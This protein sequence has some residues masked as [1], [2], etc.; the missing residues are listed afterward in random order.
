MTQHN[1]SKDDVHSLLWASVGGGNVTKTKEFLDKYFN[2]ADLSDSEINE[3]GY[4]F[5]RA[6]NKKSPELLKLLIDTYVA[7]KLQGDVYSIEYLGYK[8]K[9]ATMLEYQID[10]SAYEFKEL[11]PEIQ[12]ILTP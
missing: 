2:L 11:S 5:G 4:L 7:T 8:L 1:I 9:L 6:I 12:A 10:K 3:D